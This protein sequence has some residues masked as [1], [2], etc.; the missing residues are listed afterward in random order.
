MIS[1][2]K[3]LHFTNKVI[4]RRGAALTITIVIALVTMMLA[5][6][7]IQLTLMSQRQSEVHRRQLQLLLAAQSGLDLAEYQCARQADYSGE[8]WLIPQ[9]TAAGAAV[10]P[11][12]LQVIIQLQPAVVL[13][14]HICNPAF[15]A[16]KACCKSGFSGGSGR[17]VSIQASVMRF[18]RTCSLPIQR[19][20]SCE[21]L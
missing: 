1:R 11:E 3:Q 14:G 5:G 13:P 8:I 12:Q 2:Q 21:P 19:W 9:T 4:T 10:S 20:R 15:P 16:C 6:A 18:R 7:I 17:K